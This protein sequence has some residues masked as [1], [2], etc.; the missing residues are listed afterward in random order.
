MLRSCWGLLDFLARLALVM[1][2]WMLLAATHRLFWLPVGLVLFPAGCL[3][4]AR[5]MNAWA[6]EHRTEIPADFFD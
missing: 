4:L 5:F 3:L 1:G 6:E 2:P